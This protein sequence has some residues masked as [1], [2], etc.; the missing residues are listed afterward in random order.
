[1]VQLIVQNRVT[2]KGKLF[3][4]IS[5]ILF[6]ISALSPFFNFK[7]A[8]TINEIDFKSLNAVLQNLFAVENMLAK[9]EIEIMEV[10]PITELLMDK[11]QTIYNGRHQEAKNMNSEEILNG[12]ERYLILNTVNEKWMDH[13]DSISNLKEGIGLRAYGQTNPLEAYKIE[14]YNMFEELIDIIQEEATKAVFSVRP[15]N[16]VNLQRFAEKENES[17]I[18]NV[19]TN[20]GATDG[21]VKREPVKA[22]KKIGR[23]EPCPCG[24]GKKY[25]Q[26]CGK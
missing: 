6:L 4:I 16:N 3:S 21:T 10:E 11:I 17:S 14:C 1:V 19:T 20:E 23:N 26:C 9:E 24:S 2:T 7:N 25:K 15:N 12:I 22:E 18:K 13:I 8:E 5:L